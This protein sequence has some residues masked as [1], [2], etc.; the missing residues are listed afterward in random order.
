MEKLW[1]VGILSKALLLTHLA[2]PR[3]GHL[4]A[5]LHVMAYMVQK[6]TS[7]LDYDP[8]YHDVDHSVFKKVIGQHFIEMSKRP[9]L[10]L[11]SDHAGDKKSYRWTSG[12][13]IYVNPV[14]VFKRVY[15]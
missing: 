12:F 10:L 7:R 15:S 9:H 3:G 2:S 14:L 5:A 4:K 6:F 11:D 1:R 8:T 13:L